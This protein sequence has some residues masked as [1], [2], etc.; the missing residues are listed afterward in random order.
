VELLLKEGFKPPGERESWDFGIEEENALIRHYGGG[1]LFL[2]HHPYAIKYFNMKR[3]RETALS[4]DLLAPPLGEISGG[5]ERETDP[6]KMSLQLESS[7]MLK[8]IVER[9]GNATEFRWYLNLLDDPGLPPRAGF[10]LGFERLVGFLI[11]ADDILRCL[12]FPR[13]NQDLFP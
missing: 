8:A 4:V 6:G 3:E 10:G 13:T 2:T 7:R 9:G 1:P 11:N 12:E 5:G